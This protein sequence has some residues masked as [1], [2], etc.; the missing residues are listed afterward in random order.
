[1]TRLKL[2][3]EFAVR[4]VGVA[5]LMFGLGCYFGYDGFVGYPSAPAA[6]LYRS[7][8]GRDAP[9]GVDL[10]AFKRQKTQSQYGFLILSMLAAVLIGG[11]VWAISR[12]DFSFDDEGF[13]CGGRRFAYSDVKSVDWSKW[14]SKGIVVVDGIRLDAWH[15]EGVKAFAAKLAT[16]KPPPED[17]KA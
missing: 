13:S 8:E 14:T 15:H 16:V 2:N 7:S 17:A 4:H 12:F 6:E 10:E 3:R 1:M 9:E 5:L 11:H